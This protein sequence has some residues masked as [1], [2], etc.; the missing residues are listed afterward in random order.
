M[1]ICKKRFNFYLSFHILFLFL[2]IG[3]GN[4]NSFAASFPS[5][6]VVS[7][8]ENKAL[9]RLNAN[10]DWHNLKK[11][12]VLLPL[13]EVKTMPQTRLTILLA[14][15]SEVRVAPNSHL[16]INAQTN[17]QA[18]Q[19]D[20]Q[21]MLGRVWA[22]FRKN[23]KLRAKLILRTAQAK[24]NVRGTSYEASANGQETQVRVFTGSVAVGENKAVDTAFGEPQEIAPPS[25]V[26]REEWQVIVAAFYT[27]TIR[28]NQ[29]PSTPQRFT[30]NE[31]KS[32]WIDWNLDR[33]QK[34]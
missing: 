29:E 19:Y 23:V 27:I 8:L 31:V 16:R 14:D 13:N 26:S 20:F 1:L 32:D 4:T 18:S 17:I 7:E 10:S 15:G 30:M 33:D 25:E 6:I 24:I 5:G 9:F 3:L 12:Q 21:L 28:Q 34:L 22:K 2:L 11:G